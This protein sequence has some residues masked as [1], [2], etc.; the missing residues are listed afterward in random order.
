MTTP[1][2]AIGDTVRITSD[3]VAANSGIVRDIYAG[4]H[5]TSYLIEW[6]S[7]AYG[8]PALVWT[9]AVKA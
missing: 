9:S 7:P 4:Q 1:S 6:G 8:F 2:I 3:V 5:G